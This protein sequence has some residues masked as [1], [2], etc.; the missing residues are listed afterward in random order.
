M[1]A[2]ETEVDTA[3]EEVEAAE[4]EVVEA[5]PPPCILS[6]LPESSQLSGA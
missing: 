5:I 2:A 1:S 4:A 3:E 6:P